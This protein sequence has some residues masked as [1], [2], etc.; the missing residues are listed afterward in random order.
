M[1]WNWTTYY[2]F[3][4]PKKA[5]FKK[6]KPKSVGK[7]QNMCFPTVGNEQVIQLEDFI[8]VNLP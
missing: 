1:G 4:F 8:K 7:P 5:N 2:S 6:K 3:Y